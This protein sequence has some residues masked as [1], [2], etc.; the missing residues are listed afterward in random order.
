[1][2]IAIFLV[3]GRVFGPAVL[4]WIHLPAL[5]IRL[6]W[7]V[8]L[9]VGVPLLVAWL[10]VRAHPRQPNNLSRRRSIGAMLLGSF[11]GA[12]A[13]AAT[14]STI[15]TVARLLLG[16]A[17]PLLDPLGLAKVYGGGAYLLVY[18]ALIAVLIGISVAYY[19]LILPH[20]AP[21]WTPLPR[22]TLDLTLLVLGLFGTI[23]VST[24]VVVG[25]ESFEL[26]WQTGGP[27]VLLGHLL[28]VGA[29]AITSVYGR[30]LAVAVVPTLS[31]RTIR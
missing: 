10:G 17:H 11:A 22:Q 23:F 3:L 21:Y 12:S 8:L 15:D 19:E 29:Y 26:W 16:E 24:F 18:V 9:G 25:Y 6:L 28:G 27:I 13:L 5:V 1:M 20:Q 14:W 2:Y 30:S 31:K 7:L 4:S